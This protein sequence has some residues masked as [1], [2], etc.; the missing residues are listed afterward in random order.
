MWIWMIIGCGG[1]A[2]CGT[3]ECA[4]IC[5]KQ[6]PAAPAP[7]APVGAP[8]PA[9]A[10]AGLSSFEQQIV[11]PILEDMRAGVRPYGP[12][13]VGICKGSGKTC[14]SYLGLSPGELAEGTHMLKAELAVPDAGEKG[15]WKIQLNV[16][17]TTTR[18]S[19]NSKSTSTNNYNKEYT[20]FYAGKDRG[21]RLSPLYK[22]DSPHQGGSRECT[23][24]ITAPHPSGEATEFTGSWSVPEAK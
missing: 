17:C 1:T 13:G 11:G 8:A 22:I 12:E 6:E 2:D 10:S 16:D 15:T 3:A 5:A 24:K 9:K 14:D 7:A 19:G 20:V 18:E 21:Y 4:D 23:Y